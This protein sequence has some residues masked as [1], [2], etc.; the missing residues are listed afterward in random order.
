[1]TDKPEETCAWPGCN[2]PGRM[3]AQAADGERVVDVYM[4]AHHRSR[5]TK[6]QVGYEPLR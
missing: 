3:W 2:V 5:V 6:P 1:M 4:C